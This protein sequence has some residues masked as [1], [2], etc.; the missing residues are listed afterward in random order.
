MVN[1]SSFFGEVNYLPVFAFP[2]VK[3]FKNNPVACFEAVCTLIVNWCQYW[4]EYFPLPPVNILA[5]IENVL[6]EHNPQLLQHFTKHDITSKTYGW[7]IL[8]TVFSEVLTGK[9]WLILWD[10]IL[11]NEPSFFI[12]AAVAFNLINSLVLSKMNSTE[13]IKRFYH[14]QNL[15]DIKKLISKTYYLLKNTSEKN[16]P[17]QYLNYFAPIEIDAYPQFT[18][19]PLAMKTYQQNVGILNKEK[20]TVNGKDR[21]ILQGDQ[22]T[23]IDEVK[24]NVEEGVRMN[25]LDNIYKSKLEDEIAMVDHQRK[26]LDDLKKT[27]ENQDYSLQKGIQRTF[28]HKLGTCSCTSPTAKSARLCDKALIVSDLKATNKLI[29]KVKRELKKHK[30][31]L[32][33][34]NDI[35]QLAAE[36]VELEMKIFKELQLL[37]S[38]KETPNVSLQQDDFALLKYT[39]KKIGDGYQARSPSPFL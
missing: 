7:E 13:D 28:D 5:M 37:N 11:S 20:D 15:L 2:F 21:D 16:H 31:D 10:H 18:G 1:W 22:V 34:D 32:L 3:V 26:R 39:M 36:T 14:Q 12:L 33:H 4:F 30:N 27:L 25:A 23:K 38:L 24:R 9:D 8:Q 29:E 35:R 6:L 19:Y 17:R